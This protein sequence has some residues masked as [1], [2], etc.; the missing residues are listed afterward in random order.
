MAPRMRVALSIWRMAWLMLVVP[1][2]VAA[3]VPWLYQV[4]V[5]VEAQSV[6]ARKAASQTALV[7]VLTRISGLAHVPR[8]AVV[9]DALESAERYYS[10]FL[11]LE[12]DELRIYFD[13]SSVL[14][15]AKAAELPVWSANRPETVAWVVVE[16]AGSRE[17][18]HADHPLA[19]ALRARAVERGL[20]LHL[21]LMD[22][23]D[24]LRVDPAAVW[25]RLSS[26]I[27]EASAR[28]GADVIMVGRVQTFADGTFAA[29]FEH[30]QEGEQT[31]LNLDGLTVEAMG[32]QAIDALADDMAQRFAV[33]GR[34]LNVWRLAVG[35]VDGPTSYGRL[36][37][38]FGSLEFVDEIDVVEVDGDRLVL[39]VA[40]RARMEQL[41]Q[42]LEND[43]R[44]VPDP[45]ARLG[46]ELTWRGP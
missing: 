1:V 20:T 41:M 7:E 42:L 25:G 17:I 13:P 40:T 10:R 32:A 6:E 14:Q 38:Y 43:G 34:V 3:P 35:G 37:R 4:D 28:Y 8:N 44:I 39:A 31:A 30:W 9:R 24:Q 15:L 5:E 11:F 22:L 16:D 26:V 27:H 2:A 21:P 23:E 45:E 18:V 29:N 12:E 46:N 33:F 36:L 19:Q